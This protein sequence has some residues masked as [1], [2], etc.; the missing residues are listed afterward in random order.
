MGVREAALFAYSLAAMCLGLLGLGVSAA[1]VFDFRVPALA[2][3]AAGGLAAGT[4]R[5]RRARD[6]R[7]G[8][9]RAH[10]VTARAELEVGNPT[11]AALAASKAVST[12]A[13]VRTR[14][15]ALNTLAWAALGQGYPERA[16]AV[17]DQVAPTHMLDVFCF[18]AVEAARGQLFL[19]VQALELM[20]STGA[21]H[22]DAAKLWVECHLRAWGIEGA[23]SAALRARKFLGR[24]NCE[25]VVDAARSV[26]AHTAAARLAA[27][28]RDDGASPQ[29]ARLPGI[30]AT[31]A[32]SARSG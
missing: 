29:G 16:K 15:Q 26:G 22:G 25:L 19:A 32:G 20:L 14:N 2:L 8:P 10:L 6:A 7:D 28:I 5:L 18:A 24:E 9:A 27:A 31:V 12:A 23:V 13:T 4:A 21:L 11:T 17:L 3:L 1:G 30:V